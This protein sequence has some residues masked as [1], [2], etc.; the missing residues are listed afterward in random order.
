MIDQMKLPFSRLVRVP[1]KRAGRRET[2]GPSGHMRPCRLPQLVDVQRATRAVAVAASHLA[3]VPL[4]FQRVCLADPAYTGASFRP[5]VWTESAP[6]GSDPRR[7]CSVTPIA[8]QILQGRPY[9][10]GRVS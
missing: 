5:A 4:L 10:P 9:E 8:I 6:R 7:T 3:A 2:D 1:V